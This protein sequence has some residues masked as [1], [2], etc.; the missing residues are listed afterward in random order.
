MVLPSASVQMADNSGASVL[1]RT[2]FNLW[3]ESVNDKFVLARAEAEE[4]GAEA[5]L[6][7]VESL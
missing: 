3:L 5:R 1:I 6:S 4:L 2:E 7:R